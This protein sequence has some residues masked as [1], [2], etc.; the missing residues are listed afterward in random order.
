M[1]T[2]FVPILF[3]FFNTSVQAQINIIDTN[4]IYSTSDE[5]PQFDG[6]VSAYLQSHLTYPYSPKSD[7]ESRVIVQFVVN[8]DGHLSD[9]KLLRKTNTAFDSIVSG[10]VQQM[11][12]WKPGRLHGTPVKVLFKLPVIVCLRD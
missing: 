9:I 8:R 3:C 1:K 6:N 4:K 11:P 12:K 5:L 10:V 7:M 2:L